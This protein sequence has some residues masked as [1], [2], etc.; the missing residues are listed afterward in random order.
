[1]SSK[2]CYIVAACYKY[3]PE[4]CGLLNS[5]DYIGNKQDV[6]VIGID[7]PETFTE[8]FNK[9]SYRVIYKK[10]SQQEIEESKGISEVTCRKRYWYAGE[11]GKNYDAVCVLDADLVFCRDPIQFFT[12][13]EKTGYII[14]PCKEQNKVYDDPHHETNKGEWLVPK[15]FWNDKDVCNCPV[16]LDARV[17]EKALK[18]SW[19]LFINEGYRAPDLD[20]MNMCFL[21]YGGHDKIIKLAGL[22]WLGTNEQMLKPYVRVVKRRDDNLWTENGLE[23]FSFHGQ[24]YKEKWRK[25]Q[26]DNRHRCAEGYLK[27]S[28][29]SDEMAKGAMDVL[30][31]RFLEMLDYKIQIEKKVYCP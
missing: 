14:G 16:F 18:R 23:I 3:I 21:H 9:L 12:I 8:Q 11:I 19:N 30:Y 22:Q 20:A 31:T 24:Y 17:W 5:L 25:C 10:I 27:A 15:G 29:Q 7:L 13:A 6:Y 1:M 2:F 4:L 28:E 26:L